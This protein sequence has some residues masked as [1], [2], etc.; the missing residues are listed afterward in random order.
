M[1][2]QTPAVATTDVALPTINM[3]DAIIKLISDPN[4]EFFAHVLMQL[5][6]SVSTKVPTAGVTVT[7]S[8]VHMLV[9]PTFWA[10]HTINDQCLLLIH[11]M[12][13]V[14]LG[15]L[16]DRGDNYA[17]SDKKLANIAMDAAIHEIVTGIKTSK[18]LG[19]MVVTV[20]RLRKELKNPNILSNE[21]SEY[22]Y[23]FLKQA[24][25]EMQEKI[26]KALETLDEHTFMDGEGEE[27]DADFSRSL[28]GAILENAIRKTKEGAGNVPHAAEI[29]LNKLN[30]S[31]VNW[32]AVLRRYIGSNSDIDK[33]TSRNRRNRRINDINV[34]G[35]RK[36][37]APR[38]VLC[39]DTS[40]SMSGDPLEQVAA[41]MLAMT[42]MGYEIHVVEADCEVKRH[43]PFDKRKFTNFVGG[44][45]TYYQSAIDFA[46]KLKP[47]V[48]LFLGDMDS[49][50][51]PSEPKG[52]PF[53]W[54][55]I[56]GHEPPASFG[57][58]IKVE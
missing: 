17:N 15:H 46:V 19:E 57:K 47:D 2:D 22:Y 13:H 50:D 9:N 26:K 49:A 14:I 40:G 1:S 31:K 48:I 35:T 53:C 29:T 18:G 52:I 25:N 11:E 23:N 32:R 43:Y 33:R 21:T 4:T 5:R 51:I 44:G 28:T 7:K 55:S 56:G 54:I 34:A 30:K 24:S 27:I 38:I 3:E 8:G 37:F 36:K 58:F 39:V 45:G 12:A 6:I 42:K 16:Y 41:E 20:E 10:S